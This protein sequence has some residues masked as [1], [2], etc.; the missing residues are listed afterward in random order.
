MYYPSDNEI[1]I[2]LILAKQIAKKIMDAVPIQAGTIQPSCKRK[3]LA[4]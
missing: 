4:D 2:F 1:I 3:I